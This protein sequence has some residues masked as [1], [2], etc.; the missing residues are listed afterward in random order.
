MSMWLPAALALLPIATILVLMLGFG[1]PA[2][3]AGLVGAAVTLALTF[4]AFDFVAV[5]G[6]ERPLVGVLG[7]LAEAGFTALTILWIVAGALCLHQLQERTGAIVVLRRAIG[8]L[9]ADPRVGAL[10]IAWLFALFLEG[11][12]GFGTPI[13][14]AAPFLVGMGFRPVQAVAM[15]LVGHCVGVSFGAVGTPIVPQMSVTAYTGLELSR[16]TAIYHGLLGGVMVAFVA[17][18]AG[19][20][21][22]GRP[23]APAATTTP[24]ALWPWAALAGAAYLLPMFSIAWF[25]GPELPTLGGALIGAAMFVAALTLWHRREPADPADPAAPG[26]L[27]PAEILRAASPYL[28]VIALILLTRLVA[29]VQAVARDLVWQWELF[30]A[31]RGSFQPLYHPGTILMGGFVLGGL[32]QG[33]GTRTLADAAR[34]T[35]GQ[36]AT[37]AVALVAMLAI[38]RL[39]VHAGLIAV[40]AD[41]AAAAAG[42]AWPFF[43]PWVGVLGSFITGSATASNILFSDFQ[44]ATATRLDLPGLQ[45]LGAQGFGASVGNIIAP[46]NII[47]G[48]ATVGIAGEEGAILR[49]TVVPC[50]VYVSL[51]GVLALWL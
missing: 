49:K 41:T 28:V 43:A 27:G 44:S 17:V 46:H 35:L 20:G 6:I 22:E 30:G 12:A 16:A 11:A 25:V 38:S 32:I 18:M 40:L 47:A 39:M 51:G 13:A 33:A 19:R 48:C 14:L 42:R 15:T 21:F 10:L 31:F 37:V 29:P 2:W 36:L 5:A 26:A 9:T 1:Q 50:L 7:S 4:T 23:G 34:A 3:R 24:G 45:M 8:T